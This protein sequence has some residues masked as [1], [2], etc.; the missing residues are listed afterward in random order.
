MKNIPAEWKKLFVE[1]GVK[2]NELQDPDTRRAILSAVRQSIY[3]IPPAPPSGQGLH[4]L[5]NTPSCVCCYAPLPL[6]RSPHHLLTS[7]FV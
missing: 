4:F 5:P 1:A 7:V 3:G 2:K 6:A